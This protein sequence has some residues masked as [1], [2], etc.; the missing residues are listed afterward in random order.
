MSVEKAPL[1]NKAWSFLLLE[2]RLFLEK[3]N[4]VKYHAKTTCTSFL[5]TCA[6]FGAGIL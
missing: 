6:M 3:I 2:N 4:K 1:I 5:A